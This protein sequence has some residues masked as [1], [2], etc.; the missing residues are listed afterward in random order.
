VHE[1]YAS[2]LR[3]KSYLHWYTGE[4][5]EEGEFTEAE[6]NM[7]DLI[8]EYQQHA[9]PAVEEEDVMSEGYDD[10]QDY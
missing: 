3:R 8:N 6:S 5:M 4:G 1:H 9:E 10:D 7:K 2:L